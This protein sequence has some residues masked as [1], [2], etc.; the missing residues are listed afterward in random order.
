MNGVRLQR[1]FS[2]IE[3][4]VA[5]LVITIGLLGV[6]GLQALAIN[7]THRASLR[8][9]AALEASSMAAYLES[10]TSY[11]SSQSVTSSVT[12]VPLNGLVS[13]QGVGGSTMT[14]NL[15]TS[16]TTT[17]CTKVQI[18]AWDLHNWGAEL[19]K[20]L[21]AGQG[22]VQCGNGLSPGTTSIPM[23]CVVT[24]QWQEKS[25]SMNAQSGSTPTTP[26]PGTSLGKYSLVV[27][28]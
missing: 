15:P 17:A 7:N 6:A 10:N 27:Q 26:A 14:N 21:P 2:L 4:M 24:V 25:L 13:F 3:A 19:G 20:Q 8:S 1:G 28:P 11:W 16:C 5:L 22:G 12:V 18:A 23:T 9:I